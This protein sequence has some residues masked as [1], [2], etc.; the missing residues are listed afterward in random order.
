MFTF[1]NIQLELPFFE[2]S[3]SGLWSG[4][5][6]VLLHHIPQYFLLEMFS[7]V[8]MLTGLTLLCTAGERHQ[9]TYLCS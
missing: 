4:A 1:K 8:L 5:Y 9:T 3:G 2:K 7:N 6:S